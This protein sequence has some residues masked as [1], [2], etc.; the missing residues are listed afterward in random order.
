MHKDA[1]QLALQ[2][3]RY[4]EMTDEEFRFMVQ[5]VDGRART[6]DKLPSF[7]EEDDW[8]YPVR[9]SCEQCSSEATARYKVGLLPASAYRL[10]DLTG[11]YGVDTFFMSEEAS[12]GHYVEQ[13]AELCRIVAHNFANRRRQVEI[14]NTSAE[15]FLESFLREESLGKGD[16][17]TI[18]YID[19]ARRDQYGGKV[20]RIEDCEPN[21]IRL[22]PTLREVADKLIIKLSPMLDISAALRSLG[23]AMDVHI[24]AVDNEV[25]EVLLVCDTGVL[26]H[27]ESNIYACNLP[28]C[29]GFS[30]AEEE[31]AECE[32][33]DGLPADL[34]REG[35]YIYEPN[36]AILKAGAYKLVSARYH[37][38]K[39]GKNTHLYTS[40]RLVADFPGRRWR[41]LGKMTKEMKGMH[42][43]VMTRNYPMSTDDLRKKWKVKE[44]D[45]HTIIGSRLG[46]KPILILAAKC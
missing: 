25:K 15:A 26:S 38:Q 2:R 24:V 22:L 28:E 37:V 35:N 5:Q 39:L 13:D 42:A 8:W 4:P 30:R 27:A 44:G 17:P 10:I 33:Y 12:E 7:A 19:P 46:E 20:Y 36:A 9:L 14:H 31:E 43:S 3:H 6:R 29:F 40:Q 41:I 23:M 1:S 32:L 34:L 45:T 16:M 18:V 21:V 11:G